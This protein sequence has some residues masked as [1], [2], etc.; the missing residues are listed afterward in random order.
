MKVGIMTQPLGK[1]YGGVL[2]N[3]ALQKILK[4][5]GHDPVTINLQRRH[6]EIKKQIQKVSL[7]KKSLVR[8]RNL[9]IKMLLYKPVL[10]KNE[11]Y[12][13]ADL[14]LADFVKQNIHIT[15]S[16]DPPLESQSLV[17]YQFDAILVGSDQV[18]RPSYSP[19]I[20]NFFLDFLVTLPDLLKIVIIL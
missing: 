6:H 10:Q 5:L 17:G 1:N 20:E 7:L 19:H 16:L 12:K 15:K 9:M 3:W 8:F 13:R 2:Q 18:W 11:S 14:N 4:Q